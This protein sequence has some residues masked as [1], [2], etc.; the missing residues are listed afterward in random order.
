MSGTLEGGRKAAET[1]KRYHG[2]DFYARIGSKGGRKLGICKG[3]AANPELARTAGAKG[4]VI[5]SRKGIKTGEGKQKVY[6]GEDEES[7]AIR[8][9]EERKRLIEELKQLEAEE[10][11]V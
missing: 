11:W 9:E 4:G 6:Y 1:N 5:S 8:Q 3:F 2:D 10:E 7:V